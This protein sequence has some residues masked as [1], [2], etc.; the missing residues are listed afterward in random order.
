MIKKTDTLKIILGV[1]GSIAAYKAIELAKLCENAAIDFKIILSNTAPEFVSELSLRSLFPAKL[2]SSNDVLDERDQMHH[3]TLAKYPELIVIAPASANM[4]AKIAGGFADCLLSAVCLASKAQLA[5]APAMN[6][7]MWESAAVQENIARL[8]NR[9]IIILGPTIGAQACGDYGYGRMIES[10]E[11]SEFI[12]NYATPKF[13]KGKKLV[14]TAG[15]TI[16]RLDPVRYISNF[17]SGKMGYALAKIASAAGA[18]VALIS[19]PVHIAPP[20]S[21]KVINI[22]SAEEMLT[23]SMQECENADIFIG[24]AAVADYK[25][26]YSEH[27][28]K[29]GASEVNLRL[30]Q[31][32]DIIASIRK[33][34]PDICVVGFAAE[35]NNIID[36]GKRKLNEKKLDVVVLNDVSN[37]QVFGKDN[38]QV[39]ILLPNKEPI[40]IERNHKEVI[41]RKILEEIIS[42]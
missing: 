42:R 18:E 3:I 32:P 37:D 24:C 23:K 20:A 27:K 39:Y 15:P 41:A 9:G 31:N 5:V 6:K 13:L 30:T 38:N 4:I 2:F 40:F 25:V 21:T 22:E 8:Q 10:Q 1:S 12:L 35:T 7:D 29:K 34:F 16:E 33:S 28:L 11:I 19:G 17:S 26:E 36:Y 14:I